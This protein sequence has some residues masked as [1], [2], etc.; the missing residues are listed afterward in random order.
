MVT[1][2][3][4]ASSSAPNEAEAIYE[5]L[6]QYVSFRLPV[7][8]SFESAAR[9]IDLVLKHHEDRNSLPLHQ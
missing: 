1:L 3:P 7:Y 9:A 4:R 5:I 8:Y 6:Q 2:R